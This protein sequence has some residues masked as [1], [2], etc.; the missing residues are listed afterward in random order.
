MT[1]F[2]VTV[3]IPLLRNG[4]R[5]EKGMQVDIVSPHAAHY[6]LHHNNGQAVV[7]AFQRI[8]GI[9]LRKAN[10]VNSA[11]LDVVKVSG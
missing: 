8:Y 7:D 2:R 10:A 6:P 1:L 11:H 5:L 4:I 3:K 9:D